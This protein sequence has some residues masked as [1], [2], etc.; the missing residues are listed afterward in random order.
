MN[1]GCSFGGQRFPPDRIHQFVD[2]LPCLGT[3]DAGPHYW[4]VLHSNDLGV[5]LILS[6]DDCTTNTVESMFGDLNIETLL[7]EERPSSKSE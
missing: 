4:T 7:L 6:E 3:D 2:H 1:K 5:T